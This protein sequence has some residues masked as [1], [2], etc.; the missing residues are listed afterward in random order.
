MKAGILDGKALA[1]SLQA[2]LKCEIDAIRQQSGAAP[3]FANIV[4]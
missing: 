2:A 3:V 1:V 4:V